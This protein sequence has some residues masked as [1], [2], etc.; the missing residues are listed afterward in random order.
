[1]M[2]MIN[3]IFSMIFSKFEQYNNFVNLGRVF[4]K[5][6]LEKAENKDEIYLAPCMGQNFNVVQISF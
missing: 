3:I 4:L 6:D 5:L 2:D 1:M